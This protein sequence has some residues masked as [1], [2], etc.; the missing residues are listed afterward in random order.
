[1]RILLPA[2]ID[3][4]TIR[5][6]GSCKLKFDTR[7]LSAE[8]IFIIMQMRNSEGYVCYAPNED[9]IEIPD[10]PAEVGQKSDSQRLRS[11]LYI[12][13]KQETEGGKF[14]G[15]FETFKKQEMERII[16][17]EKDKLN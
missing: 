5:K 16:Q 9:Q 7:E 8:E 11:V 3:P 15:L 6:D 14:V 12:R 13:Y 10:E 17:Q 4:P 1:M 2:T